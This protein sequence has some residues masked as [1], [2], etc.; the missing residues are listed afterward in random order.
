MESED[1]REMF[2][3]LIASSIDIRKGYETHPS[4]VEIIKQLSPMDANI[5]KIFKT[6]I[7]IEIVQVRVTNDKGHYVITQD[8]VMPFNDQQNYR[9]HATSL[10]NLQRLGLLNIDYSRSSPRPS[11]YDFIMSHPAYQAANG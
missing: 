7:Q 1:L 10:S 8:H 6:I 11:H 9:I 4:F 5:L 2:A 3:N